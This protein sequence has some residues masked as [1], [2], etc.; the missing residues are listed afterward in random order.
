M[1]RRYSLAT[2]KIEGPLEIDKVLDQEQKAKSA[3]SYDNLY[4]STVKTKLALDTSA[5]DDPIKKDSV[6]DPVNTVDPNDSE[7]N[8]ETDPV[9]ES[10]TVVTESTE[11]VA[12]WLVDKAAAAPG[13]IYD[14]GKYVAGKIGEH[15]PGVVASIKEN[16][17]GVLAGLKKGAEFSIKHLLVGAKKLKD[18]STDREHLIGKD[19][20]SI[21]K[22]KAALAN[23]DLSN[24]TKSD[25]QFTD[26]AYI[27]ALKIDKS[28]AFDANGVVLLNMLKTF[29]SVNTNKVKIQTL[30]LIS[31]IKRIM[32]NEVVKPEQFINDNVEWSGFKKGD[33]ALFKPEDATLDMYHY[34]KLLPGDT[35]LMGVY[36]KDGLIDKAEVANAIKSSKMFLGVVDNNLN[37]VESCDYI[38]IKKLSDFLDTLNELCVLGIKQQQHYL[39]IIKLKNELSKV[40][41]SYFAYLTDNDNAKVIRAE[42]ANYVECKVEYIDNTYINGS[43]QIET[44]LARYL[45]AAAEYSKNL[46]KA[47]Q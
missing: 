16:T 5:K 46:I 34:D 14:A 43:M 28:I 15:G 42:L 39:E 44:Y 4:E 35:Y 10:A 32:N 8:K 24:V 38:D 7:E 2:E 18:F 31:L 40:V 30:S 22:L 45:K 26:I 23:M 29:D 27:N 21:T 33:I 6:D 37:S 11:D 9:D 41:Q 13:A 47:H 3:D 25:T 17:P 12:K 1:R 20:N 19:K 36:P